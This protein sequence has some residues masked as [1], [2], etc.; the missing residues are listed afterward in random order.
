MPTKVIEQIAGWLNDLN[1]FEWPK[2]WGEPPDW[3][4]EKLAAT[5]REQYELHK[6]R[7][8]RI[9][10][11]LKDIC[12]NRMFLKVGNVDR[13]GMTEEEFDKWYKETFGDE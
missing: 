13:D 3:V 7:Y 12:G 6:A 11:A 1:C 2:D 9:M 5:G 10:D 8:L 4:K